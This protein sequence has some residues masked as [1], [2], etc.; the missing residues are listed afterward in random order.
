[1]SQKI[2]FFAIREARR[3]F[4]FF[5]RSADGT[6]GKFAIGWKLAGGELLLGELLGVV[7]LLLGLGHGLE[8]RTLR[9]HVEVDNHLGRR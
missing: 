1:M 8:V 3:S 7:D 5:L 4:V 9:H 2:N 6:S